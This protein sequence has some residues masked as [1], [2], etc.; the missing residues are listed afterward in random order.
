MKYELEIAGRNVAVEAAET[1]DGGWAF[2]VD[3]REHLARCIDVSAHRVALELDGKTVLAA[4]A[5]V[6]GGKEVVIEGRVL[7]VQERDESGCGRRGRVAD[8]AAGD[9]TPPMPA[10]V[11]RIL[12]AEGDRVR[13]GQGLLVVSAMK[14]EM[15]LRSP[16]DGVV[17]A[18]R[19]AVGAKV[20]PGE[21]LVVVEGDGGA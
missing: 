15:T 12:V 3:G 8:E 10:E 16:R 20:M 18:L 14:M 1:K 9:V 2:T 17:A 11:V 5:P 19:T 6:P 7:K 13:K 4:V 21:H